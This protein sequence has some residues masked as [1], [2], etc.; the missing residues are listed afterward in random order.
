MLKAAVLMLVVCGWAW[1]PLVQAESPFPEREI[2]LVI[3]FGPGGATDILLREIVAEAERALGVPVRIENLPGAGALRGAQY[4]KEAR[5][6]G[7]TLLASHQTLDLSWL[8]GEADF[9]HL[10]FTPV[11]MLTQTINIPAVRHD[12]PLRL[13]SDIPDWVARQQ[14]E[15]Y[16]GV[17][18]SSTDHFFWLRLL[19]EAGGDP[20]QIRWV[21]YPDTG[22]Q[23]LALL[24]G[25]LDLAMVNLPSARELFD[26]GALRPLGVAHEDRLSA[27]PDVPTLIEQGIPMQNVTERGVFAPLGTPDEQ[28]TRLAAAFEQAL[29]VPA[30]QWRIEEELGSLVH[31]LPPQD[32]ARQL[33]QRQR[34]L[35]ALASQLRFTHR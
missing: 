12:H 8:A 19:H 9:S 10:A 23:I 16:V 33:A 15:V 25:E 7:Y 2:E 1:S 5:P 3:P 14:G 28:V 26:S 6:D 29:E 4:V 21:R 32:Y 22:S 11:A 24:A 35:L 31:F 17:I 18:P 34:E 13:A 30:L 20:R 27:L